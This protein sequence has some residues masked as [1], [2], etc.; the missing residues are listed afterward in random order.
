M[1]Q[2]M[3]SVINNDKLQYIKTY[4]TFQNGSV[5]WRIMHFMWR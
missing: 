2:I 1:K 3:Q 4:N 5:E